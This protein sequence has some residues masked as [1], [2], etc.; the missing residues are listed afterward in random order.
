MLLIHVREG[1][2]LVWD[3]EGAS[4]L[5][6]PPALWGRPVGSLARQPRQNTQLGLPL[7]LLPEEAWLLAEE[8]LA[9]L[10]RAPGP[11]QVGVRGG[12][13]KEEEEKLQRS[14]TEQSRLALCQRRKELEALDQQIRRGRQ[15]KNKRRPQGDVQEPREEEEGSEKGVKETE[16]GEPPDTPGPLKELAKLEETFNFPLESC[17]VQLH[18]ACPRPRSL[19]PLDWRLP[20][21]DWPYPGLE[22]HQ[23]RYAVFRDLRARGYHLTAGGKFGGDFLVYPGD[24]LRFHAHFIA[25]C[26]PYGRQLPLQETVTAGR[27]GSNV[28]KT[29]LLCSVVEG[30]PVVYTSLRWSGI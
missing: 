14:H 3:A 5:P 17:L 7:S 24:P 21:P 27:L 26:V 12:G 1:R 25:L 6:R 28:K 11:E 15:L 30:G 2:A 19:Q 8:G 9:L 18:T 20:S 29:V 23:L 22:C 10:V 13:E 16:E 4:R